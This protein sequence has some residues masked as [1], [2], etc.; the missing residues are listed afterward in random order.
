MYPFIPN[1][2][3]F[4]DREKCLRW[5][6]RNYGS[7]PRLHDSAAQTIS[8]EDGDVVLMECICE[9]VWEDALL[10]HEACHVVSNHLSR[11]MEDSPGE[12][13]LAYMMQVVSGALMHAHHEW[14]EKHVGGGE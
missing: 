9:E 5:F 8:C 3:L 2:R 12:E 7:V 14:R 1:M 6:E 4:H 10:V 11:I 13:V